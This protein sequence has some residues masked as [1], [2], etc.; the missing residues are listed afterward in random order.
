MLWE[1]DK[2]CLIYSRLS[3]EKCAESLVNRVIPGR[4]TA[5]RLTGQLVDFKA[6]GGGLAVTTSIPRQ[7]CTP[8][9][10]R[11]CRGREK[12]VR[13]RKPMLFEIFAG[14]LDIAR[15]DF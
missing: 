10:L 12:L 13:G 4:Q 1:C 6:V 14:D 11:P 5:Q 15:E 7:F 9:D 8:A 2:A 3:C